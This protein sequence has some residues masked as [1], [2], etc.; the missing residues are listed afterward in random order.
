V[1][2]LISHGADVNAK[3]EMGM[4]PLHGA[5]KKG[6][7][8]I[9]ELLIEQG[10]EV[11][12]FHQRDATP[13]HLACRAGS[14]ELVEL[15]MVHGADINAKCPWNASTPLHEASSGGSK[16]V[17][18]LL[19][20]HGA[21]INALDSDRATPLNR[22]ANDDVAKTLITCGAGVDTKDRYGQMPLHDAS[23][24]GHKDVAELLIANGAN[25]NARDRY[26]QNPLHLASTLEMAVLLVQK[27]VDINAK[28][29]HAKTPLTYAIERSKVPRFSG[30]DQAQYK[31][32][33]DNYRA[34]IDYLTEHGAYELMPTK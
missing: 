25:V 7:Y 31:I 22:A 20:E 17:V 15:L 8:D 34:I 26:G 11:G 33:I 3:N 13:L 18:E 21:E 29:S 24:W 2:I 6:F 19:I 14:L 30:E 27:G 1:E 5:C 4:T 9:A 28:D 12:L 10:A 23:L 32:R 16:L